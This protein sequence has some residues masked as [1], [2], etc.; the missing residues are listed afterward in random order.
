MMLLNNAI[1]VI[2]SLVAST[3]TVV[4]AGITCRR[5]VT[6]RNRL[7]RDI[8]VVCASQGCS[9]ICWGHTYC[10]DST[11]LGPGQDFACNFLG[12]LVEQRFEC[13][14]I[15]LVGKEVK[16]NFDAFI[17]NVWGRY[18]ASNTQSDPPKIV[19]ELL[20][21]RLSPCSQNSLHCSLV[22]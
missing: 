8:D 13:R 6:V 7:N 1:I 9:G 3:A 10:C 5:R 20:C 18:N 21:P 22:S 16:N 12:C 19:A 17:Q 14:R 2:V 15:F 4:N 11:T